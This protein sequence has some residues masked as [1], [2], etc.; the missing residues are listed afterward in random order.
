ME[1]GYDPGDLPL[2]HPEFDSVQWAA[3]VPPARLDLPPDNINNEW[4]RM[5]WTAPGIVNRPPGG[6]PSGPAVTVRQAIGVKGVPIG[7]IDHE[8]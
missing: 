4:L 6:N 8:T 3:T 1:C 2:C 7:R 5:L